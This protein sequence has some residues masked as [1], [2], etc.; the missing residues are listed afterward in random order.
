MDSLG[1]VFPSKPFIAV[2]ATA[3]VAYQDSIIAKFAMRSSV[4]VLA[5]PNR[6]N[7]FYE[8]K[9]RPP[10]VK[11]SNEDQFEKL[12]NKLGSEL[13]ELKNNFPVTIVYTSLQLCGFGYI[14]LDRQLGDYQY[15]PLGCEKIPSNRLFAQFHSRQSKNMKE[16]IIKDVT[17]ENPTQRL[18]L[19]T[20]AFGMGIDPPCVQRVI[21]FGV[22]RKME[23]YQQETG[24]A[25][26]NGQF[27]VATMYYNSN[28][29]AANLEGMDDSMRRLC[30]NQ[31]LKCRREMILNYFNFSLE[32]DGQQLHL[33]CDVCKKKCNCDVCSSTLHESLENATCEDSGSPVDECSEAVSSLLERQKVEVRKCLH[34]YK[35]TLGKAS[36]FG[37]GPATGFTEELIDMVCQKIEILDSREAV[38]QH[39]PVWRDS[40]VDSI[41]RIVQKVR[42]LPY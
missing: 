10:A 26:R 38:K 27:A 31:N 17:R 15:F 29:I 39:L 7:I 1:S 20:I 22:P 16:E 32:R 36:R 37:S 13:K 23:H 30:R 6:A 35:N 21:H 34:E 12:I 8:V 40:H 24:R 25:G 33:C 19:V 5:H 9:Q 2:T 41:F 3:P 18:L 11:E 28:D 4:R 42:T 14:L